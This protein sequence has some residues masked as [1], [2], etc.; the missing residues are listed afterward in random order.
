MPPISAPLPP[1]DAR[2]AWATSTQHARLPAPAGLLICRRALG[3]RQAVRQRFLVPPCGGSN[4]PA[5]AKRPADAL[6]RDDSQPGTQLI[7]NCTQ[8]CHAACTQE[9]RAYLARTRLVY[10]WAVRTSLVL[11]G[12][13]TFA[14]AP[15]RAR[16]A[17]I[18]L[19]EA[20]LGKKGKERRTGALDLVVERPIRGARDRAY[21]AACATVVPSAATTSAVRAVQPKKRSTL[22]CVAR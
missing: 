18:A 21:Q 5:P 1:Q 16:F 14:R 6:C 8:G 22:K 19:D 9:V 7:A 11:L 10:S 12:A 20:A 2:A 17:R 15:L 13:Y 3:R 4:P